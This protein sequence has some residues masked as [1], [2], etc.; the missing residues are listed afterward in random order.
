MD[1]WRSGLLDEKWYREADEADFVRRLS[2]NHFGMRALTDARR[3]AA[4]YLRF[5]AGWTEA[6]A[7]AGLI[8]EMAAT[9][10]DMH[11]RLAALFSRLPGDDALKAAAAPPK[12]VWTG[13]QRTAQ[14]DELAEVDRLEREGDRLARDILALLG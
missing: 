11:A 1:A 12:G 10:E 7:A 14:A 13:E 9:Y 8:A 3:C 5:A 2:V 4:A 6:A